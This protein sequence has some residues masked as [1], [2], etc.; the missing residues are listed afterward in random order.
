M[1]IK[2]HGGNIGNGT[3]IKQKYMDKFMFLIWIPTVHFSG[4]I[5][6]VNENISSGKKKHSNNGFKV[7]VIIFLESSAETTK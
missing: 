4:D 1:Q 6:F 3:F 7:I 5:S 2:F